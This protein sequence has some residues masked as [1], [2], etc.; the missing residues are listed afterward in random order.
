[1]QQAVEPVAPVVEPIIEAETVQPVEQPVIEP[2]ADAA[3][4]VVEAQPAADEMPVAPAPVD[5]SIPA[6]GLVPVVTEAD[7]ASEKAGVAGEIP[8]GPVDVSVD[9]D[10]TVSFTPLPVEEELA[11]EAVE[12]SEEPRSYEEPLLVP[13]GGADWPS[14]SYKFSRNRYEGGVPEEQAEAGEEYQPDISDYLRSN[15]ML[16]GEAPEIPQA[17]S[18]DDTLVQEGEDW[19]NAADTALIDA[20]PA[21]E[22]P[23]EEFK[24]AHR[25]EYQPPAIDR[26]AEV[27][28]SLLNLPVIGGLGGDLSAEKNST[29]SGFGGDVVSDDLIHDEAE[30]KNLT[31]SFAPVSASGVLEPITAE[32]L[33]QYNEDGGDRHID[34]A[35]DYAIDRR[36]Q[37]RGYRGQRKTY[38]PAVCKMIRKPDLFFRLSASVHKDPSAH[39]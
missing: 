17:V 10:S 15:Y 36:E 14:G 25:S 5:R 13:E 32:M 37:H 26:S 12:S 35:V 4:P 9:P 24:P 21:E 30:E 7:E 6:D 28:V 8:E 33:E 3:E 22:E 31:G 1:M 39:E 16:D 2:A 18:N 34:D 19:L 20:V 23:A 29:Q 11:E 27:P 38:Q